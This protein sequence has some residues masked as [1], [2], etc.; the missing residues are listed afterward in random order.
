MSIRIV[1]DNGL[2]LLKKTAVINQIEI[3][4]LKVQFGEEVFVDGVE[5][6]HDFFYKKMAESEHIPKTGLPS[7]QD[8]VNAFQKIGVDHEIICITISAVTSGTNQSAHLAK[9][10]LPD[11]TI[12]IIDSMNISMSTRMLALE[13]SKMAS[14]GKG[15]LEIID[16]IT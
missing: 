10:M 3:V 15:R 11:Y 7:P 2:D 9:E 14:E 8:F 12:D 1:T 16:T 4:P 13:A 6:N 5:I